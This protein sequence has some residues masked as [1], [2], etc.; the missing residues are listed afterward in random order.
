[1]K[2]GIET[3][4]RDGLAGLAGAVGQ[5]N[6]R[7]LGIVTL[8]IMAGYGDDR[9]FDEVKGASG[10]PP[11]GDQEIRHALQTAHRDTVPLDRAHPKTRW[12]PPPKL[13]PPLGARASDFVGSMIE[14]GAGS[15]SLPFADRSPV[16]IPAGPREQA[17]A[18]LSALY[19]TGDLL[20]IGDKYDIGA[21]GANIRTAGEWRGASASE[22]L[23]PLVI[24]NP[25]SGAEGMT[26]EGK[27]SFRCGACVAAFR[28]ALVEFDAMSM[29]NQISFWTGVLDTGVLPVRSLTF[30]GNKSIHALVEIG[31][32]DSDAWGWAIDTLLFAVCNPNA[33]KDLQADRACRNAD[34]LT[35]LPGAIRQDKGRTQTLL[36]LSARGAC[37][38]PATAQPARRVDGV[39]TKQT[40]A[41]GDAAARC[42]DCWNW[43]PNGIKHGCAAGVKVRPSPDW[44]GACDRFEAVES[45]PGVSSQPP[46]I[47]R[48]EKGQG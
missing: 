3:K 17:R 15:S 1:M 2:T 42:R 36:W 26:K 8:G 28:Y 31:V 5:R 35:R 11:L 30:S 7:L 45:S 32:A 46:V 13:V 48:Q 10:I 6:A 41:P 27:P 33:A 14:A 29:E 9:I 47:A 43:T 18:F 34:R 20:F 40:V 16:R 19:D 22:P 37:A 21:V 44:R 12:T 25:L 4:Y 24:A 38:S 23:P 39:T